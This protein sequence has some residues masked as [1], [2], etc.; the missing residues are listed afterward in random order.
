MFFDNRDN[1]ITIANSFFSK[2]KET[3][4]QLANSLTIRKLS[5]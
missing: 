2:L 1:K 5:T 3:L 4:R